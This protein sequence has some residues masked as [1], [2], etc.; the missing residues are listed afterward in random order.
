MP[1]SDLSEGEENDS[2]LRRT[3]E[4]Q[5]MMIDDTDLKQLRDGIPGERYWY[6]TSG[7]A[8]SESVLLAAL[9]PQ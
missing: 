9:T 4:P 7:E 2:S 6:T 1:L 5:G 3:I 8:K